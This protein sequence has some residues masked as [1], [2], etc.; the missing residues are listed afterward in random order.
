MPCCCAAGRH[1]AAQKG[2]EGPCRKAGAGARGPGGGCRRRGGGRRRRS[3]RA[4]RRRRRRRQVV[5]GALPGAVPAQH[6]LPGRQHR[7]CAGGAPGRGGGGGWQA[8]EVQE[9]RAFWPHSGRRRLEAA[10]SWGPLQ[11]PLDARARSPLAPACFSPPCPLQRPAGDSAAAARCGGGSTHRPLHSHSRWDTRRPTHTHTHTQPHTALP[12]PPN[13]QLDVSL[14]PSRRDVRVLTFED[15]HD[16]MHCLT[17]MRQWP[18]YAESKL[19]V[20]AD[21]HGQQRPAGSACRRPEP[22][23]VQDGGSVSDRQDLPAPTHAPAVAPS[24]ATAGRGARWRA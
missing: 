4:R 6:P 18:E 14:N 21:L 7:L 16:C 17:A 13:P 19:S 22:P 23:R 3:G 24:C 12:Q 8:P 11:P 20:S 10:P 15:R 1:E 9:R 2:R 5:A